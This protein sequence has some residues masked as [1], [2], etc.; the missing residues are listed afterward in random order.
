[1]AGDTVIHGTFAEAI[2]DPGEVTS[3]VAVPPSAPTS[4]VSLSRTKSTF[5]LG[6]QANTAARAAANTAMYLY[7]FIIAILF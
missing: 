1:M 6:W 5:S 4:K 7:I 3:M 2:H